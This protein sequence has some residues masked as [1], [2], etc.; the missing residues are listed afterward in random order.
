MK[1]SKWEFGFFIQFCD[2]QVKKE[3]ECEKER[4]NIH[5]LRLD[6]RLR[7]DYYT[8]LWIIVETYVYM[9]T[10]MYMYFVQS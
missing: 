1:K 6:T 2:S 4:N 5:T 3:C 10:S 8:L 9:Y 7:V